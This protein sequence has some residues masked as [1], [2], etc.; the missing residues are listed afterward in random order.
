MSLC[1]GCQNNFRTSLTV[2]SVVCCVTL[3]GLACGNKHV[4]GTTL[5]WETVRTTDRQV[6]GNVLPSGRHE[7]HHRTIQG[8]V[9]AFAVFKVNFKNRLNY[10]NDVSLLRL[11][12]RRK[13]Q[14]RKCN[15]T[16]TSIRA[17]TVVVEKH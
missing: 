15:V 3:C 10:G 16:L 9:L 5:N 1:T 6:P 13:K 8:L 17:T 12:D 14:D 2:H 7:S 4:V 11:L